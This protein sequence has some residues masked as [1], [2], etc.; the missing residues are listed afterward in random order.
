LRG[1]PCGPLPPRSPLASLG[2][3]VVIDVALDLH[4]MPGHVLMPS[5]RIYIPIGLD[6]VYRTLDIALTERA[7]HEVRPS[8]M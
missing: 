4:G 7:P 1:P 2:L 6:N 5:L 3:D 8:T